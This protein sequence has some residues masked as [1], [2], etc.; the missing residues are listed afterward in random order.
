[1]SFIDKAKEMLHL[2]V[3]KVGAD[4]VSGGIDKAASVADD[5]TGGKYT[6]QIDSGADKAKDAVEKMDDGA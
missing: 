5:K 2:G 1:M 6:E 3:D 4:K